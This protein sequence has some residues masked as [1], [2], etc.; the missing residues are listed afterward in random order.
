M[1][2]L[3]I[4]FACAIL[5]VGNFG[6]D[7][8]NFLIDFQFGLQERQDA[9]ISFYEA[10]PARASSSLYNIPGVETV[11]PFRTTPVR[12]SRGQLSRQTTIQ[13]LG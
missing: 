12:L 4:A 8:V 6:K 7:A 10:V 13:G 1:T 2:T 11:E 3:G 5:V 9:T